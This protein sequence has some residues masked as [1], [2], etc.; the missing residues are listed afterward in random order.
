MTVL[1]NITIL[2][3]FDLLP[4]IISL[5]GL[6]GAF[7]SW[8]PVI[9]VLLMEFI[10]LLL[11]YQVF[12]RIEKLKL[13]YGKLSY[14]R[15]ILV[16]FA[17]ISI[18]V[19]L[20]VH[21]YISMVMWESSF[22]MSNPFRSFVVPLAS[23][24]PDFQ[25]FFRILGMVISIFLLILGVMMVIRT[26]Q[27]FGVDYIAVVYLYFPE[28]SELQDHEIFSILRHPTY[29][30]AIFICLGGVFLQQNLYSLIFF[31]IYY[32]GFYIHVHFVEEKE[33]IQ[34]FGDSYINYRKKVP[35][36]FVNPK[37]LLLFLK[38]IFRKSN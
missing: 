23:F 22:W 32:L 26:I 35:A 36:F 16:G 14:Q 10:G 9:G 7:S 27:I 28:E 30:A 34:R 20:A 6:I 33:L 37:N 17:G 13:K 38:L 5:N 19:S 11:V 1:A 3:F 29:A 25:S 8:F 15:I 31:I 12:S 18:I 24:V 4:T 21:N 2:R